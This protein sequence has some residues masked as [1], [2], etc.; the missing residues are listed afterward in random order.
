MKRILI[1]FLL[2]ATFVTLTHSVKAQNAPLQ[3]VDQE[4]KILEE[5]RRRAIKEGDMK[6]LDAIYANDFSGIAGSGQIIGK[7]Q[8]MSVFKRNDPRVEFTTD[9]ISVRVSG[10]TALFSGRL[11]GRAADGK[12]VSSS[13]F[14]HVFAR[15][16]GRWQCIMG[17][18]TPLP[19]SSETTPNDSSKVR[20]KSKIFAAIYER[21]AAFQTGK[22][23]F[24]QPSIKEH[25][26]HHEA[27]GDK[28]IAAGPLKALPGDRV[29]GI[30][31]FEAESEEAARLWLSKDPAIA[32]KVLSGSVQQWGASNIR[33]YR[34]E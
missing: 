6:T 20:S 18:S 2:F 33:G 25:I 10:D 16:D 7:E 21:G 31:V 1:L 8:L 29:V 14:T 13:R 32:G 11:T 27:L 5:K 30:I 17:Q 4:L 22:N 23:I 26:A 9:E 3:S 15:R 28:L 19:A 24:E 34:R 12:I